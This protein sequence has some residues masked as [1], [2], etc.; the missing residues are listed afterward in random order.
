MAQ[1]PCQRCQQIRLMLFTFSIPG[2]VACLVFM[3]VYGLI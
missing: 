2:I 1:K 3:K